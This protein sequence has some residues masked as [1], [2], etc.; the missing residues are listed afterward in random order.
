M[1]N[2]SNSQKK[3]DI[4]KMFL[5]LLERELFPERETAFKTLHYLE[6][7]NKLKGRHPSNDNYDHYDDLE[8]TLNKLYDIVKEEYESIKREYKGNLDEGSFVK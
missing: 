6:N 2:E 4:A 8:N 5:F 1:I 3:S 7:V